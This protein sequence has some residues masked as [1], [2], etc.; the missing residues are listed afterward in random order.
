MGSAVGI[1]NRVGW[2]KKEREG[3][4]KMAMLGRSGRNGLERGSWMEKRGGAAVDRGK[5]GSASR[6]GHAAKRAASRDARQTAVYVGAALHHAIGHSGMWRA[7]LLGG[8]DEQRREMRQKSRDWARQKRPARQVKQVRQA[9]QALV[10]W[11]SRLLLPVLLRLRQILFNTRGNDQSIHPHHQSS[12]PTPASTCPRLPAT[13][14]TAPCPRPI[15]SALPLQ[16][17]PSQYSPTCSSCNSLLLLAVY[18]R[19]T[20]HNHHDHTP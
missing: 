15:R 11:C 13:T 12:P 19:P 20:N 18:P 8:D 1:A 7:R 2:G 4:G 3:R 16:P 17:W 14:M 10:G 6:W 5:R 9:T